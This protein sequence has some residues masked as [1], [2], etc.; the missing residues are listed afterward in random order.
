MAWTE[1]KWAA[2]QAALKTLRAKVDGVERQAV[3]WPDW[4]VTTRIDTSAHR[5][6]VWRAVSRHRTLMSIYRNR[7]QLPED[8]HNALWGAQEFYRVFSVVNGGRALEADVFEGL[9]TNTGTSADRAPATVIS[10][11]YVPSAR[12]AG[13]TMFA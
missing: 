7:Q 10:K 12:S 3:P 5:P 11:P 8:H 13:T 2:Y 1:G 4:A 6:A 9:R